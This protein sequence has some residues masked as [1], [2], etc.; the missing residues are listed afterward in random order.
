MQTYFSETPHVKGGSGKAVEALH[1]F[2]AL[3][4]GRKMLAA[5]A[6]GVQNFACLNGLR[7]ISTTWV[8]MGHTYYIFSLTRVANFSAIVKVRG[9]SKQAMPRLIV[10]SSYGSNVCRTFSNGISRR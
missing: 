9:D 6:P 2:S 5:S 10:P 4:N 3:T 1:C 8:I 7:V